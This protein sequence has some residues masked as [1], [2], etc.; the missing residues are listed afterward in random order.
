MN[1]V[2]SLPGDSAYCVQDVVMLRVLLGIVRALLRVVESSANAEL[3]NQIVP[4]TKENKEK[5]QRQQTIAQLNHNFLTMVNAID[6]WFG[7][8]QEQRPKG[9]LLDQWKQLQLYWIEGRFDVQVEGIAP[10]PWK[11][12]PMPNSTM[13]GPGAGGAAVPATSSSHAVEPGSNNGFVSFLF[14]PNFFVP[15]FFMSLCRS[16]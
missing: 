5:S 6:D 2:C 15:N 14:V 9:H 12:P 16:S 3:R 4:P 7:Q 10:L 11:T 1:H 13:T 8:E